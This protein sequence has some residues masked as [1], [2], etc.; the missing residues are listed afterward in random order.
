MARFIEECCRTQSVMFP[1]KLEDYVD[2]EN[3]V[4]VVDAFV[5]GLDLRRLGFNR[6]DPEATGRPGYRPSTMLKLYVYGYLNRIQSSRRLERESQ[7]NVELMWLIG[8]LTPD[9]KTI[10]D[11]RKN[12]GPAIQN[13]CKEFVGIC[14]KLDLFAK[15]MVAIDGSKFKGV[16]SKQKNDT[17]ASMKRRIARTEKHIKEYMDALDAKD[18]SELFELDG[19]VSELKEKLASLREHLEELKAREAAVKAHPDK[20]ISETDPDARLMKQ[21]RSGSLVGY[22]VQSAVDV[23]HKLIIAHEVTN[24]PTDRGQLLSAARLAKDALQTDEL[25]V[26][27]DRG[28]FKGTDIRDCAL[29]NIKTL[30]PKPKTS[31]NGARGLFER[32]A[33]IYEAEQDQYRCPAGEILSRRHSSIEKGLKIDTYYASTPVCRA[34]ELKSRCTVGVNRRVR[35]WEHEAV[36]ENAAA[37]LANEPDAMK[38]RSRTVEHPFGTMKFRMGSTHFLMKELPNVKT[39]MSLHVLVYNIKR[40]ISILG[41]EELVKML[42]RFDTPFSGLLTAARCRYSRLLRNWATDFLDSRCAKN[43]RGGD[44]VAI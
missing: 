32:E 19:D 25:T 27:A 34:C 29:M 38:L 10:A 28:Y 23:E 7:R 44:L 11:F 5:D 30:V 22:N 16:N 40:M 21:S 42:G 2:D 35:R 8:K 24:S 9:F 3:P 36:L 18:K 39:E 20:Q 15:A 26:L 12:N 14:R 1:E 33:F 13:V 31:N 43:P 41:V 17:Q 4:R 6:V 37:D